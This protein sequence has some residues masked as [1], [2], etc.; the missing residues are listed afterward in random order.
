VGLAFGKKI[1]ADQ[2]LAATFLCSGEKSLLVGNLKPEWGEKSDASLNEKIALI[3]GDFEL[4]KLFPFEDE[5]YDEI[6]YDKFCRS[7]LLQPNLFIRIR[8]QFK[9][10]TLNKILNAK[11]P[12]NKTSFHKK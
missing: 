1:G 3:N 7:F 6:D 2:L 12:F 8:P 10:A 5:L 9:T 11:I 4:S